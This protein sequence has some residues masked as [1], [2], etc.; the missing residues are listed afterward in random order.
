MRFKTINI[1]IGMVI[2]L[3]IGFE[4][5]AHADGIKESTRV[6]FSTRVQI[7]GTG[8]LSRDIHF[9]GRGQSG[10]PGLSPGV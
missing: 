2:A 10:L 7:P 1:A 4:L 5:P 3:G 8:T 9:P 6:T